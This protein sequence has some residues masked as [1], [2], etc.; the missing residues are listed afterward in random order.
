MPAATEIRFGKAAML[1][2]TGRLADID[3]YI[4]D[5]AWWLEQKLDGHR[6]MV[7]VIDNAPRFLNRHGE[8]YGHG[9]PE[10]V[11]R[12]FTSGFSGE[13]QL[14][15]ELV[16]GVFWVFDAITVGRS[17]VSLP[18]AERRE[19]VE[20]LFKVWDNPPAVRL[21]PTARTAAEKQALWDAVVANNGEG[22]MAKRA[23]H[24]YKPGRRSTD[25]QKVKLVATADVIVTEVGRQGKD[26]IAI[27]VY[28][29]ATGRMLDAGAVNMQGKAYR[30]LSVGDVVEVRYLYTVAGSAKL[31]QP[32]WLR[33]R[34]DKTA[35]ECTDRQLK[36]TSREVIGA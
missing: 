26:S 36:T 9:V 7:H 28:D 15:G 10:A 20:H 21:I 14:D 29:E 12:A 5:D 25:L 27:G 34:T 4:A 2:D 24:L 35:A 31:V 6:V 18:Y 11:R 33:D 32:E 13:W 1:A 16:D 22:V 17:M 23:S 30:H 19:I 3:R 8:E